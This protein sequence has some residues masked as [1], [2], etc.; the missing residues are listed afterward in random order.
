MARGGNSTYTKA[1]YCYNNNREY[2]SFRYAAKQLGVS[3][4][5]IMRVVNGTKPHT[6][7]LVFAEIEEGTRKLKPRGEVIPYL[8]ELGWDNIDL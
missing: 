2:R 7:G 3:A 8:K 5:S 6:G 1:V 4:V